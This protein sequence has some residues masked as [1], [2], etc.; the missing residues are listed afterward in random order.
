MKRARE[1]DAQSKKTVD[2]LN[3]Q[4]VGQDQAAAMAI[5]LLA[6]W[7]VKSLVAAAGVMSLEQLRQA[8]SSWNGVYQSN[9]AAED[10]WL[11]SGEMNDARERSRQ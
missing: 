3:S 4:G 10:E 6:P 11:D 7:L 8:V 1:I 2:Y 5:P 9:T